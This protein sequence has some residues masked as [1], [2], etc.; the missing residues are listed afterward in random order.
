MTTII[1]I[2]TLTWHDDGECMTLYDVALRTCDADKIIDDVLLATVTRR[3][4]NCI[5][6]RRQLS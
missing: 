5:I 3:A 1:N 6:P 4:I 2:I